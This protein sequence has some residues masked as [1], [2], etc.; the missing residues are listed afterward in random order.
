MQK[1]YYYLLFLPILVVYIVNLFVD[2]MA[3][4]ASQYA[5]MSWEMLTTKNFLKVHALGADYLDKPPLLFWLNSLSF[6]FFGVGNVSYKLPSLFFAVLAIYSTYRFAKIYYSEHTAILAA[7]ILAST[8]ALFLITNDVRTDTM[9]MGAVMFAIWQWAQFFETD[10]TL[11]LILGGIGLGLAMLAKGPIGLIAVSAALLPHIILSK[12]W[13]RL[14]DLRV[15]FLIVIVVLMLLP[16]CIGLYQQWGMTGLKFYFWTQSFGRITGASEWNNNPDTFFLIHTTIWAF[17][18]WSLFLFAG[19][20]DMVMRIFKKDLFIREIISISGFTLVLI[21][22]MLSRY[23]LP[24]Y[25][26]VVYPL[27]AVIAADYFQRVESYTSLKI[28]FT[29]IQVLTLLALMVVSCILQY[30]LKG[31]DALSLSCLILL[32]PAVI[33]AVIYA[34]GPVKNIRNA[35]TYL[36]HKTKNFFYNKKG[37]PPEMHVAFDIIYRNLFVPS[38]GIMIVFSFLMGAFYF[39]AILKYQPGDDFG[40]YVKEHKTAEGSFVTYCYGLPYSDIF[41]AQQ[42]P[43]STWDN[44]LLRRLLSQKKHLI[45]STTPFGIDQLNKLSVKYHIIQQGYHYQVSKLTGEFLN[46]ASREKV[47]DKIYLLEADL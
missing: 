25:I 27:G 8:E 42:M 28:V 2:V 15:V 5:E 11:H 1:K 19:W 12:K 18:P 21:A 3:I 14:L 34:I 9:L 37:L 43:V 4:D 16:M 46:P 29:I 40:R 35:V 38:M 17:L 47:C 10:E 7:L 44:D 41:Y 30:C 32:Y 36:S 20:I 23:Q 13:S 22:L 45:I 31:S 24:H 26:F 39:P 33:G 6:Y